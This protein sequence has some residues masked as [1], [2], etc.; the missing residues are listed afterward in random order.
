MFACKATAIS[1]VVRFSVNWVLDFVLVLAVW[2]AIALRVVL[3]RLDQVFR[4]H[5]ITSGK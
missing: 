3:Q 1:V 2:C 4:M 5:S